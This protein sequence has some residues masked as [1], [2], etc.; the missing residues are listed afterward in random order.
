MSDYEINNYFKGKIGLNSKKIRF[1]GVYSN[2]GLKNPKNNTI[3]VLNLQDSSLSGSHWVLLY[4]EGPTKSYYMDPYG[5]GPTKEI[6]KFVHPQDSYNKN[7]Y[8]SYS[9]ESCGYHAILTAINI[10]N[11]MSPTRGLIPGEYRHNE[12]ILK[13][14]FL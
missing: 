13:N 1:G 12:D 10:M 4:Y 9:Q 3:Y 8:Q 6:S 7:Q 2:D 5:V 11:N 14:Y